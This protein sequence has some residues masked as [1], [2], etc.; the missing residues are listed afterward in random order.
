[1]RTALLWIIVLEGAALVGGALA[2]S[3]GA[4]LPRREPPAVPVFRPRI[5]EGV[6]GDS[7]TY[8]RRERRP[9]GSAGEVLG[10]LRYEATL[11][12][13]TRGTTFG[14]EF[15]I[16]IEERDRGGATLQRTM[17]VRPRGITHGF[18]PPRIDEDDRPTGALPVILSISTAPVTLPWKRNVGGRR[19]PRIVDGFL[20][21]AVHPRESLT[22]VAERYWVSDEVALFGVVRWDRGDEIL[23][24]YTQDRGGEE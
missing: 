21:E 24:L 16:A 15:V 22:E 18:L 6:I 1:M 20:I 19:E 4:P 10:Y 12:M 13:E 7:V 11:A 14:R 2:W 8:E 17:L 23:E 3:L 9:D 5:G